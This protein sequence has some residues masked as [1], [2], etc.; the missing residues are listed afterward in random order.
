MNKEEIR[1]AVESYIKNDNAKY[2][3]LINGA[4]G[5]GKTFLYENYLIDAI[6]SLEIGKN[7]RKTNVYISLYGMPSIEALSKQLLSN[8]LIYAKANG[9]ESVKKVAKTVSGILGAASRAFS[10]SVGAV[11]ADLGVLNEISGAIET[12]DLVVCFDDLER[13]NISITEVFGYINNL[14]EHCNCKVIILADENNIG[15]T[16]ANINVEQKYQTILTGGRKVIRNKRIDDG[17]RNETIPDEL[18]IKELKQ[19]NEALYSENYIYRDIKEKV[20]GK[21]CNYNPKIE[22]SLKDLIL[23]NDKYK[24]YL[25][26]SRYRRFLVEYMDKM[27]NAFREVRNRNLRVVSMWIDLFEDIYEMTYKNFSESP[28]YESIIN[29]FMRY[30][31]WEAVAER[32]DKRLIRSLYYGENQKYVHVEG[33]EYTHAAEYFFIRKYMR[34]A[35]LDEIE[36]IKDARDIEE[37][38]RKEKKIIKSEG[39]AY[40]ELYDW[41]YKEDSE[42][43]YYIQQML[44]ELSENKYIYEDYAGI[45][46]LLIVLQKYELYEENITIV[47]RK[48]LALI[49]NDER[50]QEE[51]RKPLSFS[52]SSD[53]QKFVEVYG[54]IAELRKERNRILEQNK[55]K[56]E[57]VYKDA[58]IFFE[59]CKSREEY[60][61]KNNSFMEYINQERLMQLIQRSKTEEIHTI[62]D[63]FKNVYHM[64]NLGNFYILD[65]ELL[66][67]L[68][69]SLSKYNETNEKGVTNRLAVKDLAKEIQGII[70]KL[71]M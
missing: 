32:T 39:K 13:C 63:A 47:Q 62:I 18:T 26:D 51:G 36:L 6:S 34:N 24:G 2:A 66:K 27:A 40:S 44:E 20:I 45:L 25:E 55:M 4:W 37:R 14:I 10:F 11:S 8:Y 70:I 65:I 30:S 16:Y 53:Q 68:L 57:N 35:C 19:L 49:E 15:K 17:K 50:V 3:L 61:L 29:D 58:Q 46:A 41:R 59:K 56:E 71:E 43:R 9:N 31:I 48:M 33:H 1:Q 52:D 23:G 69:N 22:E 64:E 67:E 42:I 60:Y 54:S 5:S 21:T 12:R 28:Y 38:C 7:N